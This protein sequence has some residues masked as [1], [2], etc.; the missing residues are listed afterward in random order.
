MQTKLT[1]RLDEALIARAKRYAARSGQSV[2]ELVGKLFA[3]LEDERI[4][5][6]DDLPPIT[7]ALRGV[8]SGYS[9]DEDDYIAFLEAKH[10]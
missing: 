7:R 6:T 4:A 3:T 9:V 10:R 1:L 2:S 8:L 5:S